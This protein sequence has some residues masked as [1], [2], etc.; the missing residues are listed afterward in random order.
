M[1]ARSPLSKKETSVERKKIAEASQSSPKPK[2]KAKLKVKVKAKSAA[3]VPGTVLLPRKT[4][5][6][7]EAPDA[8]QPP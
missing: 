3:K 4:E 7:E 5:D 2:A 1:A 6:I 8:I